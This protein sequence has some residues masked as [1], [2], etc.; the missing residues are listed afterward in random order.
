[1]RGAQRRARQRLHES[2]ERR[3]ERPPHVREKVAEARA[4]G[5]NTQERRKTG[6]GRDGESMLL[7]HSHGH[8]T[9]PPPTRGF[10]RAG[11]LLPAHRNHPCLS[12]PCIGVI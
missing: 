1:L 5:G 7:E 12:C 11:T 10:R 4:R 8:P 3:P 2:T 9:V 6:R